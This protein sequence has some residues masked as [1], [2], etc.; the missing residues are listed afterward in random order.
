MRIRTD[1]RHPSEAFV[2]AVFRRAKRHHDRLRVQHSCS[3]IIVR[4]GRTHAMCAHTLSA[5]HTSARLVR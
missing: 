5:K 4:L 1:E 3:H 2:L